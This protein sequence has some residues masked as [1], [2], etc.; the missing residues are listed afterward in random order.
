MSPCGFCATTSPASIRTEQGERTIQRRELRETHVVTSFLE[1]G[2]RILILRRSNKV[3]S[4][5]GRWGGVSGYL[6]E[7]NSPRQQALQEI[8]EETGLGEA[9][10]E[11]VAEGDV[12]HIEDEA[13]GTEWL[14]HPFRFKIGAR[15]KI[16]IDWEHIELAWIDPKELESHQTV[17][18]LAETWM[19]VS[20]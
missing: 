18:R 4:Y 14:V 3:G 15:D 17:P 1:E 19:K 16:K 11:Q 13:L 8:R 6:D 10:V 2:G 9:D 5:Q 12:L 7:G 20:G